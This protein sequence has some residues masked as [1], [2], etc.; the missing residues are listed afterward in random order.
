MPT[1]LEKATTYLSKLG[2]D[3]MAA[4]AVSEQKAQE[5]VLI[6]AREEGF[7]DAMEIFGV[8][9]PEVRIDKSPREKSRDIHQMIMQELTFSS[10]GMPKDQIAK[11]IDY[12]SER[13]EAALKRLQSAGGV[14]QNRDGHWEIAVTTA[15]RFNGHIRAA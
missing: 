3:R 13:T 14:T 6:K 5:A 11:A 7:R 15:R 8:N 2:A 4:T 10:R 9:D 1:P 12:I